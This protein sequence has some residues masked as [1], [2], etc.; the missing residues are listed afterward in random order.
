MTEDA[1]ESAYFS[2]RLAKRHHDNFSRLVREFFES[3]PYTTSTNFN[4]DTGLHEFRVKIVRQIPED[5]R[6]YASD[7]IKNIRD[8]LDQA[9]SAS[10]FAL[11]GKRKRHAHFPFG[12]SE[13]DLENSL[14]TEADRQANPRSRKTRNCRDIPEEL[15]EAIRYI[16]PYPHH[17]DEWR[18]KTLQKVSGPHKH[19]VSLT[20]GSAG[21]SPFAEM[22]LG[23]TTDD[24]SPMTIST[25]FHEW[26]ASETEFIAATTSGLGPE[27]N[28]ALG[29][30]FHIAFDH[31]ELKHIAADRLIAGW[32]QRTE[33]V[34]NGLKKTVEHILAERG[35]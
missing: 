19:G 17:G 31:P 28:V 11:T 10:V 22:G 9:M 15:F 24:G 27:G 14:W 32:G 16:K 29:V 33:W 8:A 34:I 3:E 2:I 5:L 26:D 23:G 35:A 4:C 18:L 25:Q 13:P 6:G 7:A 30:P 20:L 12:D 21:T 1:F